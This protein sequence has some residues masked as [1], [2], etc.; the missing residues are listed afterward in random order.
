MSLT[1]ELLREPVRDGDGHLHRHHADAPAADFDPVAI[2]FEQRLLAFLAQLGEVFLL[3][4]LAAVARRAIAE[5]GPLAV[6]RF[7]NRMSARRPLA[8]SWQGQSPVV[9]RQSPGSLTFARSKRRYFS[10]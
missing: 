5:A 8:N 7:V 1:I 3:V 2:G 6:L 10:G 4:E 9:G